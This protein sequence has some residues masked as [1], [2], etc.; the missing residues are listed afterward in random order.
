MFSVWT[1]IASVTCSENARD[2]NNW[3]WVPTQGAK[4]SNTEA[5]EEKQENTENTVLFSF[6]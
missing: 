3:L 6:G 1:R 4:N 2:S 5:T